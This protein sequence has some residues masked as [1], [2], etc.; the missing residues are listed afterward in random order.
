MTRWEGGVG[1]V[2]QIFKKII[3]RVCDQL[4]TNKKTVMKL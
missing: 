4:F 1:W 2:L 3:K